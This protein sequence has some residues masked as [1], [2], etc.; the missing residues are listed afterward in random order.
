MSCIIKLFYVFLINI[1][2]ITFKNIE[3][4]YQYPYFKYFNF[5]IKFTTNK[6]MNFKYLRDHHRFLKCKI[7]MCPPHLT[8][9]EK[10]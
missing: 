6:K 7:K 4:F 3:Y 2:I 10:L 5:T 1:P 8:L 9:F